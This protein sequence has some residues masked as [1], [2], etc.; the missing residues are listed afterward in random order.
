[1]ITS[2]PSKMV[3]AMQL[4]VPVVIWGPEYCS[5]VKWGR[6]GERALCVTDPDPSVLR[7]ELER[8]AASPLKQERLGDSAREAAEREFNYKRIQAQFIDAIRRTIRGSR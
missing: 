7:Q 3:D 1:M 8:L 4:G 5:A 6:M 2:F